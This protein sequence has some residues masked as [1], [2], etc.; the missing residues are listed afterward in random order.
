MEKYATELEYQA[1]DK[2]QVSYVVESDLVHYPEKTIT[3]FNEAVWTGNIPA[4][5]Y[6]TNGAEWTGG[7]VGTEQKT[8]RYPLG[9]FVNE[10]TPFFVGKSNLLEVTLV[11]KPKNNYTYFLA[12]CPNLKKIKLGSGW[13]NEYFDGNYIISDSNLEEIEFEEIDRV[14]MT[15][16]IND[17][18]KFIFPKECNLF[19]DGNSSG[20]VTIPRGVKTYHV[21]GAKDMTTLELL[22]SHEVTLLGDNNLKTLIVHGKEGEI[23]IMG[24]LESR[25]LDRII[26]L[27]E[28]IPT[29]MGVIAATSG[30]LMVPKGMGDTYRDLI[31]NS[32][33][34]Y[35]INP[36]DIQN[37]NIYE[38]Q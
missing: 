17:K 32:T 13:K 34:P 15:Q 22:G 2:S 14:Y 5:G 8:I 31:V 19:E 21:L 10:N 1:G 30:T 26:I 33:T 36:N 3:E 20:Y 38:L 6:D 18:V 16:Y 24:T 9:F 29:F 11:E 35:L 23:T 25:T 27:S 12:G 7:N 4:G 37:W 28:T